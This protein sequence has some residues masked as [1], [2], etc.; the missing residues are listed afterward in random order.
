ML[1]FWFVTLCGLFYAFVPSLSQWVVQKLFHESDQEKELKKQLR[2]LVKERST[3]NAVDA[4]A[5]YA[6]LNR[7]IDKIREQLGEINMSNSNYIYKVR[8][9]AT[10][11]L[12]GFISCINFYLIWFYRSVPLLK[13]PLS[14]LDPFG[15]L[16]IQSDAGLGL[17]PWLVISA[18]VGRLVISYF[19][20]ATPIA[21][22]TTGANT[23][24]SFHI[25]KG[26]GP[27]SS[28]GYKAAISS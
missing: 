16:A 17:I 18:S 8:L 25:H 24:D 13:V 21:M 3:V 10:A 4:F 28:T 6:K 19:T 22:K 9:T 26:N 12:Y 1:Y 11:I 2:E 23:D 14:W 7:R 20:A 27:S 15:K 5:R